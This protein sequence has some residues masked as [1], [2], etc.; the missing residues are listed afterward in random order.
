MRLERHVIRGVGR[1]G[2][3]EGGAI[4][5]LD[6]EEP[7]PAGDLAASFEFVEAA[8]EAEN[9]AAVAGWHE[10]VVG[11]AKPELLPQLVSERLGPLDKK[12]LPVV[13]GV[14]ALANRRQR[15]LGNR[16]TGARNEADV[17]ARGGDLHD[18]AARCRRWDIDPAREAGGRGIG[19]DR[20]AGIPRGVLM[21]RADPDL[22]QM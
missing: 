6:G 8:L 16:L 9:V 2:S 4:L 21:D 5:G 22:D 11:N 12:R 20:G 15:R 13:A 14:E 7:R 18:L 19:G 10:D 1:P 3:G 17:S